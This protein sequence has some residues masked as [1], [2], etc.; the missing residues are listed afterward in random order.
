MN[1]RRGEWQIKAKEMLA[2]YEAGLERPSQFSVNALATYCGVSRTSLWRNSNIRARIQSIRSSAEEVEPRSSRSQNAQAR[3]KRENALLTLERDRLVDIHLLAI[4]RL[5]EKGID[6]TPIF[7][8]A[9]VANSS[10]KLKR[11]PLRVRVSE[12]KY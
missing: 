10:S 8:A 11:I 6:P 1:G 9:T 4:Q 5:L 12:C 7:A 2:L 3:L